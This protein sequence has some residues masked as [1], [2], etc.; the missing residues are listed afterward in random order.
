VATTSFLNE[1]GDLARVPFG[2][3]L[4]EAL[5]IRASGLLAVEHDGGTS[6]I[7]LRDGIPVG[8]QSFAGFKPLGQLFLAR[9]RID[10]TQLNESLA[11]MA[12]TGRPQGEILVEIGAVSR[13][14]VDAAL[15]EQQEEYLKSIASLERG[16]YRLEGATP[17]PAWTT[18]VRIKPLKAIVAALERPQAAALVASALQPAAGKPLQLADGY[19]AL[20]DA[21]GWSPAERGLV[22]RLAH[23]TTL[24]DFFESPGLAAE[25]ARAILAGLL[26]LGLA[27]ARPEA[28]KVETVPGIVVDIADLAGVAVAAAPAP[29]STP[30]PARETPRPAA[31]PGARKPSLSPPPRPPGTPAPAAGSAGPGGAAAAPAPGPRAGTTPP[32]RA[33]PGR[34]SDP[35]EARRRRQR[36]LQR[37]MQNMGVGPLS[38]HRPAE[39]AAGGARVVVPPGGARPAATAAEAELRKAFEAAAP[40]TR[41]PDLFVRL[42]LERAAGRDQVK[43]AFFQ[44]A[45]QLHPDRFLAP[46]LADLQPRVKE[47]FAA[48][49]EAYET[50]SD[51]RRRADYLART[52]AGKAAAASIGQ[53]EA[54]AVDFQKG[55][56]CLRTRDFARARGFY[57]AAVRADARPDY[58][59]ALAWILAFDP[60]SSDRARAKEILGQAMRDGTSDRAFFTAAQIARDEEDEESAER[61]YRM[62]LRAN[63]NHVE[64]EREVRLIE[65]RRRRK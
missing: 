12:A 55:E 2:A 49:N 30:A 46:G 52:P 59:A 16:S 15:T 36:L 35:A 25:R 63:P 41:M 43:N 45:R 42:G 26:L 34:R 57:E 14:E 48:L 8:S 1:P 4:I 60:K 39:G 38:G 6:K 61:L 50:L 54:A 7:F 20:A 23:L 19:G 29:P 3:V 58:Q 13:A 56:A 31:A 10:V 11:G 33:G 5:N 53:A 64:A 22:D 44:L 17:V 24:E 40:R 27:Q 18:G 32:P 9:G 21:F 62:A 37:A 51:D 65:A 28:G 47:L